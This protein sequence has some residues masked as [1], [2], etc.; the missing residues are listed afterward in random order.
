MQKVNLSHK[1]V[2]NSVVLALTM[3]ALILAIFADK[4]GLPQK[5]DIAILITV[6]SF[7]GAALGLRRR[8]GYLNF[9]MPFA[10]CF[11]IHCIAMFWLF[12]I[13]LASQERAG[14]VTA[15]IIGFGEL[16]PLMVIIKVV[17]RWL[18]GKRILR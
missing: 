14:Y 2:E 9:W 6:T 8:W 3:S 16:V 1:A 11:L 12:G 10:G 15:A 7:G 13:A 17:D 4:L 18:S 5:W